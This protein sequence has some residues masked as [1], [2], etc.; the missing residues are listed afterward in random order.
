MMDEDDQFLCQLP[1]DVLNS[2]EGIQNDGFGSSPV[3]DERTFDRQVTTRMQPFD[4]EP[5]QNSI[6]TIKS[7]NNQNK[8][9]ERKKPKLFPSLEDLRPVGRE[10]SSIGVEAFSSSTPFTKS[11]K[12]ANNSFESSVNGSLVNNTI[13]SQS[14]NSVNIE[15]SNTKPNN[16]ISENIC[17]DDSIEYISNNC[18]KYPRRKKVEIKVDS[19]TKLKIRNGEWFC[20]GSVLIDNKLVDVT[21]SNEVSSKELVL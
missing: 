9:V 4:N 14:F 20:C 17:D 10:T 3:F 1:D 7:P 6:I 5:E 11:I 16:E 18:D 12:V 13:K 2:Q 21:F 19:I 15:H 8:L